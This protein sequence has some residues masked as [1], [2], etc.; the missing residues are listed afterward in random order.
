VLHRRI[1]AVVVGLELSALDVLDRQVDG[2]LHV[3]QRRG[4]HRVG[5]LVLRVDHVAHCQLA[6]F[7]GGVGDTEA[8]GVEHVGALVDHGEGGFLGLR[9]VEPAVDE[10]D[11]EF[12]L[13][14]GFLGAGHEGLHQAVHFGDGEAADHADL[15]RLGHAAG[16][17]AGEVGRLL[18][19]VV[20]DAE[21]GRLRL[22]R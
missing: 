11:G 14:V 6:A 9:G 1:L 2:R 13:R 15:V 18:D 7:L 8:F 4:E 17:H 16:D 20:E 21:V 5:V 19:V 22:A 10:G 3:P 12:D